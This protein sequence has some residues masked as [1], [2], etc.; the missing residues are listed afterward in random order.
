[1]ICN[2]CRKKGHKKV[3]CYKLKNKEERKAKSAE[4]SII[5][6]ASTYEVLSVTNI[7][8]CRF[9]NEW[10]MDSGC[11]FHMS[12]YRDWFSTYDIAGA[13]VL[14][15]NNAASKVVGIGSIHIKMHDGIVRTLTDVCHVLDLKKNLIAM[16]TS[17]A[18][19]F[20]YTA[21]GGVMKV[22]KGALIVM[23]AKK[24]GNSVK[25]W[26]DP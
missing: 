3:D 22:S 20:K 23:K 10:I 17:D 4:A 13:A 25:V 19:G 8:K 26:H 2:C 21:K 1:M 14:M 24:S 12:P 7:A 9:S 5:E 18:S 15:S 16:G 6:N 11:S